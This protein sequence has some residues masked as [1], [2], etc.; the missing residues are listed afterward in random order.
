MATTNTE[1]IYTVDVEGIEDIAA[2]IV[3]RRGEVRCGIN[4]AHFIPE[5]TVIH[6]IYRATHVELHIAADPT[7]TRKWGKRVKIV[8]GSYSDIRGHA[9]KR[10]VMLPFNEQT[11]S[12]VEGIV[13]D[14]RCEVMVFRGQRNRSGLQAWG[15]VVSFRRDG[16]RKVSQETTR[17]E[18][19]VRKIAAAYHQHI[20]RG[21]IDP[22]GDEFATLEEERERRS[23]VHSSE[24][25]NNEILNITAENVSRLAQDALRLS[26]NGDPE[27][28]TRFAKAIASKGISS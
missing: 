10:Y 23:K 4:P 18:F 17:V 19:A 27:A 20:E 21:M 24:Y 16:Y 11:A 13:D 26:S 25:F 6:P 14:C 12:L 2:H 7:F 15:T 5:W 28:V 1:S 8:G 22:Y 9:Y 3:Q